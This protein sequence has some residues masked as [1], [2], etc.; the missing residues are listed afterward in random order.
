MNIE[1]SYREWIITERDKPILTAKI[2][3][4]E[5]DRGGQM[6]VTKEY[7]SI[8][9]IKD[10]FNEI[11]TVITI[12]DREHPN[13]KPSFPS[14]LLEHSRQMQLGTFGKV[15][16]PHHTEHTR[17][18]DVL[19]QLGEDNFDA[20]VDR[21]TQIPMFIDGKQIWSLRVSTDNSVYEVFRK[22]DSNYYVTKVVRKLDTFIHPLRDEVPDGNIISRKESVEY[23]SL[24]AE[25]FEIEKEIK[26]LFS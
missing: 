22:Y 6:G 24:T 26:R 1:T 15:H 18:T 3:C 11:E 2:T 9:A 23:T 12:T 4:R 5:Y 14:I 7:G 19:R 17:F 13:C 20:R 25:P 10:S 8:V 16:A 21:Y